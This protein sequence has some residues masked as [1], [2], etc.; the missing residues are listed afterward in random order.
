MED[1]P[2]KLTLESVA[3]WSK[4]IT[5]VS[6]FSATGC[7]SILLIKGVGAANIINI[8]LAIAFFLVTVL[9]SWFIQLCAAELKQH[10]PQRIDAAN[11][12]KIFSFT[13]A[14][15]WFRRLVFI[16]ML[17]FLLSV[18]FLLIWIWNL[19]AK[20]PAAGPVSRQKVLFIT[21]ALCCKTIT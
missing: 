21:P 12:I 11:E 15:K 19:P 10:V 1:S 3:D 2:Q 5:G 20:M 13:T 17:F 7:V 16:E 8:K 14:K 4:W 18:L 9:I 6:L